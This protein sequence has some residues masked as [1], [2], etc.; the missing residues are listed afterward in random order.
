MSGLID[1]HAQLLPVV[2]DSARD[3]WEPLVGRNPARVL[4]DEQP[5]PVPSVPASGH[6]S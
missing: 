6:P 2:N 4:R 3:A 5:L 1:L